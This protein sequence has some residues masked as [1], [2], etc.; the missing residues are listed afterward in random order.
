MAYLTSFDIR[1]TLVSII[2]CKISPQGD[3][4]AREHEDGACLEK[5]KS[6]DGSYSFS[7]V[8]GECENP[9]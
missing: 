8:V 7:K 9:I 5:I 4:G 2:E 3:M 1:V 6:K